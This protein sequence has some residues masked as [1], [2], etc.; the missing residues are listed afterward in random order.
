MPTTTMAVRVFEHGGPEKLVYDEF[1][2]ETPGP[3][4]VVVKVLAASVSGWDIKYRIGLP[5][6]F[7]LPGPVL[8]IRT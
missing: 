6:A 1:S 4:D 8:G 5:P 3:C 2:L 7:A